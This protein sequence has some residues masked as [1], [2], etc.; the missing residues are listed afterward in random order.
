M[1][2]SLAEIA[3]ITRVRDPFPANFR[4]SRVSEKWLDTHIMPL[5][6]F[7]AVKQSLGIIFILNL[8][9]GVVVTSVKRLLLIGEMESERSGNI[10]TCCAYSN[11]VHTRRFHSKLCSRSEGISV[12]RG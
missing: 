8:Q 2:N 10:F 3:L 6:A 5:T 1:S 9:K 4:A 7:P 11:L 12:G